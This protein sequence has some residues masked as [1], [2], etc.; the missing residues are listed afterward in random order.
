MDEVIALLRERVVLCGQILKL[1]SELV[2][3][4]EKNSS[5]TLELVQRIE[6]VQKKLSQNADRSQDFLLRV[7]VKSLG[8][9]LDAQENGIKRDVAGRLLSQTEKLQRQL[10][11]KTET[12]A[13]LTA[14]GTKFVG[15]TLNAMT[16]TQTGNTYGSNA[17]TQGQAKKHIFDANV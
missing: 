7:N 10:K 13:R 3:L 15:F 8:D 17:A 12:A 4:L 1:F 9:F 6:A 16:Q 5:D 2:G 14:M 11:T